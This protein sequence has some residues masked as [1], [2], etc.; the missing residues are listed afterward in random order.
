MKFCQTTR[1][2]ETE[3]AIKLPL[4]KEKKK[5]KKKKDKYRKGY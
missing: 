3:D 5:K 1:G 4:S 2:S